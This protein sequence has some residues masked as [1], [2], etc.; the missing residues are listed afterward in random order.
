MVTFRLLSLAAPYMQAS[1]RAVS[2]ASWTNLLGE[3]LRLREQC[4]LWSMRCTARSRQSR[5]RDG[6]PV[7]DLLDATVHQAIVVDDRVS[8]CWICELGAADRDFDWPV[9]RSFAFAIDVP[10]GTVETRRRAYDEAAV[11]LVEDEVTP[12]EEH[13][14]GCRDDCGR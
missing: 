11:R 9:C 13:L 4:Q 12:G 5:C 1:L 3:A 2:R 7:L 6:L 8:P 14:S 10:D